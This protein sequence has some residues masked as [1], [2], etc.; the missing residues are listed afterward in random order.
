MIELE[1]KLMN[2]FSYGSDEKLGFC[3][4][5]ALLTI[6][7]IVRKN[8]TYNI[9]GIVKEYGMNVMKLETPF[10]LLNLKHHPMFS[11]RQGGTTGGTAFNGA[12]AWLWAL[13]MANLKYVHLKGRDIAY[14][15]KLQSNDLDGEKSGFLGECSIEV[16]NA[17]SHYL[18]ENLS[19]AA[20]DA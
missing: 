8:S 1:E 5:R 20:V 4:R 13:D 14:Q 3:G 19:K 10:G 7:Q 18:I 16:R 6:Q 11:D 9:A 17:D 2:M 12:D 15:P